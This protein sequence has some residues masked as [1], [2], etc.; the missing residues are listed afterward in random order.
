MKRTSRKTGRANVVRRDNADVKP[1]PSPVLP[2]PSA[3]RLPDR[4]RSIY[5]TPDGQITRDLSVSEIAA[6]YVAVQGGDGLLWVDVDSTSDVEQD[7]L[8]NVFKL[9]PLAIEDA[10]SSKSRVKLEEYEPDDPHGYLLLVLRT[11]RF[12]VDTPDDPYDIETINLS[13]FVGKHFVVT[14]HREPAPSVD[15]VV[16][17]VHHNPDLLARGASRLA[18]MVADN[19][20]DAYFPILDEV[21]GFIDQLEE[22]VFTEFDQSA[23]PEIFRVKRLVLSLRRYLTPQRDVFNALSNRP[24]KFLPVE[25]QVYFRDV[26]D[27]VLRINDALDTYRELLSGTLD[28]YLTQV[29]NRLGQVTK[30]LSIVATLSIPFVVISG[31]WGMNVDNIPFAHVPHAF[32]VML[33]LQLGL[34]A[35]LVWL[36]K[37]RDWL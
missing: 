29:N 37:S 19:A 30:G 28:G 15:A 7:V 32:E 35:A 16:A 8:P 17:L 5:R 25:T 10:L 31:M 26:Y 4:P 24:S 3:Q 6:A 11:V 34:G 1:L 2:G 22:R 9:H 36:L 13:L 20:I 23:L 33:V 27:H 21:D 12:C 14:V 18:H